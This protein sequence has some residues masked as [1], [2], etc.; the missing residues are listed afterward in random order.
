MVCKLFCECKMFEEFCF[1]EHRLRQD[2]TKTH[3]LQFL[4]LVYLLV[5][6]HFL[7]GISFEVV[8]GSL[9]MRTQIC[10]LNL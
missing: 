5:Q 6:G 1:G 9:G 2:I 3:R 8:T 4:P 7:A 10:K